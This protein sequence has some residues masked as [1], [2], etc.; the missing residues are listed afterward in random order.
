VALTGLKSGGE[1]NIIQAD[2]VLSTG[3]VVGLKASMMALTIFE[4]IDQITLTGDMVMQDSFNLASF[5]PIIGQEY[6]K[7]KIA[8]PSLSGEDNII[9]YSKNAL[10]VT[11]LDDRQDIGNGVQM[12][13]LS[14]VSREFVVNQRTRVNRTLVGTYSQIVDVMLRRD[15]D[16]NKKFYIESSVDNKKIIAPNMTPFEIIRMS[17]KHAVSQLHNDATYMFWESTRGFNFRTLGNLYSKPPIMTYEYTIPGTRSPDGV[18]NI[19]QELSTIESFR[20]SGAPDT[21]YNYTTG[22]YS[23]ELIVHDIISKNYEKTTYN[24]INSFGNER[25]IDQNK[26]RPLVNTLSLTQ[27]GKNVSS[28]PAKQYLQSSVGGGTDE[29]YEDD[30]NQYSFSTNRLPKTIQSRNSQM[31]ILQSGLSMSIDVVGTTIVSAGDIVEIKIPNTAAFKST[32]NE[33]LDSLYNSHFLI[34]SLRHDFDIADNKHTMSMGVVKDSMVKNLTT[35]NDN[36]EPKS[37][38]PAQTIFQN[39]II[40]L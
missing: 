28:F 39:D 32:G 34:K 19:I 9:D 20:I 26:A 27:D 12:S 33:T 21:L 25:H 8:T 1:F 6:L 13:V 16:S 18:K 2:L 36:I 40:T 37:E 15:L 31:A 23:S 4:D 29:S 5:G 22:V 38:R 7:L 10:M 14:F 11:S 30:S 3:K 35:P 24:Y 17:T